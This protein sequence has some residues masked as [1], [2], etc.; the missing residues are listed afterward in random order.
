MLLISALRTGWPCWSSGRRWERDTKRLA[1]RLRFAGLRQ[2]AT[3]EDVDHRAARGL[4]RALFQKL[5]GGRMDRAPPGF[6][7]HWANRHGQDLV[8][9]CPRAS[10]LSRQPLRAVS[11]G[12]AIAGGTRH[13]PW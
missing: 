3:P 6:A 4:D 10:G 2:Q 5:T 8:V 11:A 9:V 1:T 12:A 7:R 13:C